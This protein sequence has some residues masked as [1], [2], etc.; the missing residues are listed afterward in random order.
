MPAASLASMNRDELAAALRPLWE[1]ARPIADRLH[2]RRFDSW[3]DLIGAVEQEI[4][5]ATDEWKA[6]VLRA[7]PRLGENP[8]RLKT[9]SRESWSEQRAGGD[10]DA[11]TAARLKELNR[12]YETK[13]GFPFVEWV[14]GRPLDEIAE[15]MES[16]LGNCRADELDKGSAALVAIARARLRRIET[17]TACSGEGTVL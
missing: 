13:F 6:E 7:H 1:D 11:A 2:G 5:V 15:V 10:L 17:L 16:R 8:E 14:A 4:G 12:R 3:A 9:R